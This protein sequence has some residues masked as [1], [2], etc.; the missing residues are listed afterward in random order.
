MAPGLTD[1][2]FH[3]ITKALAEPNRF[4]I[5]Q[6]LAGSPEALHCQLLLGEMRVAPATMSHH[7]KE[8]STA[9]LIDTRKD[10]Q[11]LLAEANHQMIARYERELSRRLKTT[12]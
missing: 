5:L 7:L 9:G 4:R 10:G 6:R 3:R 1:S 11:H 2:A 12:D 8:L